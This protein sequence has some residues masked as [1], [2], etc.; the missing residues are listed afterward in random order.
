[1]AAGHVQEG[2]A[3]DQIFRELSGHRIES[4]GRSISIFSDLKSLIEIRKYIV[5]HKPDLV[6]THTAKAGLIGRLAAV[7]ILKNRPAI[8]HTYHGHL[9]YGYFPNWKSNIFKFVEIHQ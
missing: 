8:I 1:M 9:L 3:E 6:N 2:E 7:S 5:E 4:L